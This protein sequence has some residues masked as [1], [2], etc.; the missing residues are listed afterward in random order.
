M[1][2]VVTEEIDADEGCQSIKQLTSYWQ[3]CDWISHRS[4]AAQ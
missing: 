2:L 1:L 3:E 4:L